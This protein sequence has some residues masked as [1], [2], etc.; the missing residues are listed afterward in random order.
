MSNAKYLK[1]F[2]L[3]VFVSILFTGRAYAKDITS[4]DLIDKAKE[5]DGKTVTFSGEV[6]GDVMKRGDYAWINVS[7]GN[8]A[9]GI[10]LPYEEAK[11]IENAG[12]YGF[13]GDMVSAGGVFN[14]ACAEHGGDLDIHSDKIEIIK[15]GGRTIRLVEKPKIFI[16]AGFVFVSA[17]LGYFI[18]KKH[19]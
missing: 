11:K 6:I 3:L 4:N 17:V 12:S 13:T 2:L 7:D 18:Y 16:A 14:R 10:W 15:M 5:Y 9:I 1:Y 8:N 19:V